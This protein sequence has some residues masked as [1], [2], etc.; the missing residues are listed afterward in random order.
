[1]MAGIYLGTQGWTNRNWRGNFYPKSTPPENYLAEYARRFHAVEIDSSFYAIP[2]PEVVAHWR[3]MTPNDF[4]F[5]AKFPRLITHQKILKDVAAET[6]QFLD[7][8]SI[9][10]EKL[11]LLV[12]QFPFN[13]RLQHRERLAEF[14]AA[15]PREFRYAVE[16]RH[17]D[18]FTEPFYDLLKEHRVALVLAD[19]GKVPTS[20]QITTDFTYVRWVGNRQD[21]PDGQV[22][23]LIDRDAELDEWSRM[24]TRLAAQ[25]VTVWGFANDIYQGHAPTTVHALAERIGAAAN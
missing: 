23:A 15:L 13:F 21:F 11:G 17:P 16:V 9:L 19:Y 25:G 24:I 14:L 2:R 7:V 5:T 12:L 20:L 3:D 10:K 4:R 8:T 1:M 22:Q 18:W 6:Q